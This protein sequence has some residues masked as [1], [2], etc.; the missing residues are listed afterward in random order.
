MTEHT[1]HIHQTLTDAVN[2]LTTTVATLTNNV[3]NLVETSRRHEAGLQELRESQAKR[4]GINPMHLVAVI[5]LAMTALGMTGG[6]TVYMSDLHRKAEVGELRFEM[7][8]EYGRRL[9]EIESKREVENTWRWYST[10]R[11]H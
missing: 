5:S 3:Q 2:K 7:E 4:A 9:V 8:K 10:G 11:D 1:S 6:F